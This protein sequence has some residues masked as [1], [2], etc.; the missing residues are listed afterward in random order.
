[1]S[2]RPSPD[3]Q[4]FASYWYQYRLT[5]RDEE[6]CQPYDMIS[7]S[8]GV[9]IISGDRGVG[10]HGVVAKVYSHYVLTDPPPFQLYGWVD[11]SSNS[12]PEQIR[13]FFFRRLIE[14][15][16][17]SPIPDDTVTIQNY[18]IEQL[19][20]NRCLVVIDGLKSVDECQKLIDANLIVYGHHSCII[21][22]AEEESVATFWKQRC[23]PY[24][25]LNVKSLKVKPQ[26]CTYTTTTSVL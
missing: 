3:S 20:R 6:L 23:P 18:V 7:T 1:M 10:K 8:R 14:Y 2:R 15:M 17:P 13:D 19:T 9:L 12:N 22:I 4:D 16:R 21:V 26:V 25:V 5:D 24:A 11:V